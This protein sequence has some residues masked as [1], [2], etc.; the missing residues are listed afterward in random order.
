MDGTLLASLGLQGK[1]DAFRALFPTAKD[2]VADLE[3]WWSLFKG[4]GTVKRVQSPPILAVSR[5]AFGYDFREYVGIP[6]Y[7]A[8]YLE[9]KDAVL[10]KEA[11]DA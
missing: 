9:L 1:E 2:F 11:L 8:K 7:S 3:R 10:A 5:R 4:M 6:W